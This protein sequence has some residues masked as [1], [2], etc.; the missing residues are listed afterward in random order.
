MKKR[1][2]AHTHTFSNNIIGKKSKNYE[3]SESTHTKIMKK[4]SPNTHTHK[5]TMQYARK[6]KIMKKSAHA[7]THI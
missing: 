6:A 2:H 1:A 5:V 3:E 4:R 7:N